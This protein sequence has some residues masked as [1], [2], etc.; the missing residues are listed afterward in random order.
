L[1]NPLSIL[2]ISSWYPSK[3]HATLGNFVKRHAEAI[4]ELHRVQ[5]LYIAPLDQKNAAR[6]VEDF[7]EKGV[8]TLIVYYR[9]DALRWWRKWKAFRRGISILQQK[10]QMQFDIVHLNVI[11]PAGWQALYL[12]K[13]FNLPFVVTEHWTGYDTSERSHPGKK[14]SWLAARVARAASIISPVTENLASAMKNFGL[15]GVY[16]VVPNVVDTSVFSVGDKNS[17]VTKF[18]HVSSLHDEQK[19]ISGLLRA[20]KKATEIRND[21]HLSIGGDGPWKRFSNMANE[22]SITPET[23]TFFS[24]KPLTDIAQ[25]MKGSDALI[26]FSNYENLPC[27]IVEALASGM[28][29]ISTDVGGISEH[30]DATRGYLIAKR[31]EQALINIIY[32]FCEEKQ[33]FSLL[34]LRSYAEEHFSITSIAKQF[35]SIYHKALQ[36]N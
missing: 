18:L 11:V 28:A 36:S 2:F 8:E 35:T 21:I 29:I 34:A 33:K 30:V 1:K 10:N 7:V 12:K 19:N 26:L 27:V 31:D 9:N 16:I 3:A 5:V 25:M 6:G 13:K 20:W 4:A 14:I 15:E 23:I 22:L 32:K 24:E 17:S